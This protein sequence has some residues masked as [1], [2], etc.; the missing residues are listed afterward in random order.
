MLQDSRGAA[1]AAVTAPETTPSAGATSVNGRDSSRYKRPRSI[2]AAS[3]SRLPR[4]RQSGVEEIQDV[5]VQDPPVLEC[6]AERALGEGAERR[7]GHDSS[8]RRSW[9][10]PERGP[11]GRQ[12]TARRRDP[13]LFPR[14]TSRR[15]F[16]AARPTACGPCRSGDPSALPISLATVSLPAAVSAATKPIIAAPVACVVTASSAASAARPVFAIA[17]PA[18]RRPPR[19]SAMPSSVLRR[20]PSREVTDAAR[21]VTISSTQPCQPAVTID[22]SA[23]TGA[24]DRSRRRDGPRAIS[25]GGD[26]HIQRRAG[27]EGAKRVGS[28]R[29]DRVVSHQRRGPQHAGGRHRHRQVVVQPDGNRLRQAATAAAANGTAE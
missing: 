19:S 10:E 28:R 5:V 3:R 21:N 9:H 13:R 15:A 8:K 7:A 11:D 20:R 16:R 1:P 6:R 26:D 25:G 2:T 27:R 4:R 22:R 24:D 18:P 12:R 17:F 29:G 23:D 14:A